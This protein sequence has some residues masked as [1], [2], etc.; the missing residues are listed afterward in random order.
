MDTYKEITDDI[1]LAPFMTTAEIM[2][3]SNNPLTS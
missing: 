2:V 3:N 1:Y